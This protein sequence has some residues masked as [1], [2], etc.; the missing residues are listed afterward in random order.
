MLSPDVH[1]GAGAV[2]EEAVLMDGVQ[3]GDGAVVRRAIIDK[4]VHVPPGARVGVDA[5]ADR[6]LFT[7]SDNGVVVVGKHQV[8]PART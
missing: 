4:Y 2:V 3:I 7:L 5:A 8:V 6:E 1:V